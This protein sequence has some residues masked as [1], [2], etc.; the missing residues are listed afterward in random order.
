MVSWH[1]HSLMKGNGTFSCPFN[2]ILDEK[3]VLRV[4]F[5]KLT[6][7]LWPYKDFLHEDF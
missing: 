7:E 1:G 2:N 4:G 3:T 6:Y 5:V